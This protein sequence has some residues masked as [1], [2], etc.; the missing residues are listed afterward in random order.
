M[1]HVSNIYRHVTINIYA[2]HC[3]HVCYTEHEVV[4]EQGHSVLLEFYNHD[5]SHHCTCDV[6]FQN[7]NSLKRVV[8]LNPN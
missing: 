8:S 7:N 4:F 6:V 5:Y 3:K 2:K 1:L